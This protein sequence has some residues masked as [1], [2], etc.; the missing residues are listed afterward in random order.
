MNKTLCTTLLALSTVLAGC[1]GAAAGTPPAASAPASPATA[2]ATPL[3]GASYDVVLE[4]PGSTAMK[5]TL[6]FRDGK[7]ESTA[8]SDKGFPRWTDYRAK[9]DRGAIAFAVVTHHPNG[10]AMVE[11][12]GT[13]H[14]GDVEGTA[15]ITM[16]G[17]KMPATFRGSAAKP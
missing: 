16:D 10:A 5:D 14:G 9:D 15:D 8:C 3:D 12:S 13:V 4:I 2:S 1:G 17:K 11:W 6:R 7:F